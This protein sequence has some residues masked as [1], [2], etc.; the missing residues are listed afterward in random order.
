MRSRHKPILEFSILSDATEISAPDFIFEVGHGGM[1]GNQPMDE[2]VRESEK[3]F[4]RNI[5]SPFEKSLIRLQI[6]ET[7]GCKGKLEVSL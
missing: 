3:F 6:Q 7:G 1:L 2:Q 5:H 4:S